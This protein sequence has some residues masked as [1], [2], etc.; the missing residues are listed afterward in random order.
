M[1]LHGDHFRVDLHDNAIEPTADAVVTLVVI[2]EDLD[3]VT[4]FVFSLFF[5]GRCKWQAHSVILLAIENADCS[6]VTIGVTAI[7]NF[8]V[9]SLLYVRENRFMAFSLQ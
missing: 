5:R 6:E 9:L 8:T 1:E 7:R 3:H 4:D 2:T